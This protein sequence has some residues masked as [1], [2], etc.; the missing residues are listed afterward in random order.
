LERIYRE[1]EQIEIASVK[2]PARKRKRKRERERKE[3]RGEEER[4]KERE[5]DYTTFRD[6]YNAKCETQ[7]YITHLTMQ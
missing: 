6:V 1:S 4:E 7:S 2:A 5:R 3:E